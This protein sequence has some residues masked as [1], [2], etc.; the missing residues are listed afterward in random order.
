MAAICASYSLS[1]D[2]LAELL[3]RDCDLLLEHGAAPACSD[4]SARSSS[5]DDVASACA[6]LS[7]V[8]LSLACRA[9]PLEQIEPCREFLQIG[10]TQQ[11]RQ[12]VGA[13]GAVHRGHMSLEP[14]LA[15]LLRQ[16]Q[17]VELPGS[18]SHAGVDCR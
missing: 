6:A 10:R 11:E 1:A 4:W 9:I 8:R 5:A 12:R 16:D 18:R 7:A 2:S 14:R 13:G 17:A 15:L 3:S